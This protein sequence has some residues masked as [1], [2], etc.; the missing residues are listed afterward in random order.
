[1]FDYLFHPYLRWLRGRSGS[2]GPDFSI[3]RDGL[4]PQP[5][6]RH[7][8]NFAA[9]ESEALLPSAPSTDLTN[10]LVEP[11][12][13]IPGFRVE[14]RDDDVPGF[15]LNGND[16]PPPESP[17]PAGIDTAAPE[18]SDTAQT[19]TVPLGVEKPDPAPQ[20]PDWL[21]NVLTMPVPRLSTAFDPKTGRRIVP[22]EPLINWTR[23]YPTVH[24]NVRGTDTAGAYEAKIG[25]MSGPS[26]LEALAT[27]QL[28]P[29]ALPERPVDF[30]TRPDRPIMQET[31]WNSWS[32]PL[33]D[34]QP[35]VHSSRANSE[36]KWRAV[37][38]PRQQQTPVPQEQRPRLSDIPVTA[39]SRNPVGI[40]PASLNE[41]SP[42]ELSVYN[43][44]IDP[45]YDELFDLV[46]GV[47]EN[48][49]QGDD[50]KRK[51]QT[52]IE[53]AN[54]EK[55]M[56]GEIRIYAEGL[57]SYMVA[58]ILHRP[59]GTIAITITEVKSGDGKL[60]L[61]QVPKLAEAILTGKIYIVNESAA[62]TL[63]IEPRKTFA[64]QKI[65]PQVYIVG[66]DQDAIKKQLRNLGV[67]AIPEKVRRGQ[68]PRL[69]M[70]LPPT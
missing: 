9:P 38:Q 33:K 56:A 42:I 44:D 23:P 12:N 53:K 30:S 41:V 27:K 22:Y 3:D 52:R 25:E 11:P 57:P 14:L 36:D 7:T 65:I 19:S 24:Q 39:Y 4:P 8:L 6:V 67:E 31:R 15:S 54:P 17:W 69:R 20:I 50:A 51:E 70:V 47:Q 45:G 59:N 18:T 32:Q 28:A 34:S 2:S 66:G 13:D 5:L 46:Q 26:S 64:D 21:Y 43:P 68:P 49:A 37:V 48:K 40:R 55:R 60:S 62:K 61:N 10:F 58:D 63:E 29:P 1:M 16:V 35:D